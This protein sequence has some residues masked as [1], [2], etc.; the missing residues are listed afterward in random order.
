[1]KKQ[2][3]WYNIERCIEIGRRRMKRIISAGLLSLMAVTGAMADEFTFEPVEIS[4]P[5]AKSSQN[6]VNVQDKDAQYM[7]NLSSVNDANNERFQNALL[8]LDSV[9]VDMRDKL[10]EYKSQYAEIDAQYNKYKAERKN[11]KKMIKQ[12]EKKINNIDKYKKNIR[13]DMI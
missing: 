6:V 12:A 13:N 7:K 2:K 11:M 10:L 4:T 9:Q 5:T 8:E 1:M 3:R